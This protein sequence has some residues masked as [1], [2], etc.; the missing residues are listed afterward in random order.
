MAAGKT[1]L[2]V[3]KELCGT[4]DEQG[5]ANGA[6][7][8]HHFDI[9]D[10][11]EE[12]DHTAPDKGGHTNGGPNGKGEGLYANVPG[13]NGHPNGTAAG[14]KG[15]DNDDELVPLSEFKVAPTAANGHAQSGDVNGNHHAEQPDVKAQLE[16]LTL[17][18]GSAHSAA[19]GAP[20]AMNNC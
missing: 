5:H 15:G 17:N 13:Q 10:D 12:G 2:Q 18:G 9:S 1:C 14:A 8:S 6:V 19:Q 20:C 11:E 16:S 3:L 4:C 7:A